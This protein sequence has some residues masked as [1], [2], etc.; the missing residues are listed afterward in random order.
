MRSTH[1]N[2]IRTIPRSSRYFAATVGVAILLG[3]PSALWAQVAPDLGA[4][5]PFVVLGANSIPVIG[6]VTCTDTGPGVGIGAGSVGTT[7][8]GGITNTGCTIAGPIVSPVPGGVVTAFNSALS[9]IDTQNAVCTGV[10]PIVSTVLPPGVYCSPAGT[11]IGAGVTL[12]LS[13]TAT[14]VWIFRV[15]TGGPGALT[16][17]GATIAMAGAAQPCNVF[18]K[19]SAA[20]T[21]TDSTFRGTVLSGAA[22]TM[23]RTTWTGRAMAATNVTLT[24]PDMTFAGC[25]AS[26]PPGTITV[27]KDFSPNNPQTVPVALT[28]TSGTVTATPLTFSE[29]APAVFTVTGAS[30]GVTCTATETVPAN[31]T[32]NQAGCV[33]V[34]LNGSCTIIN[35]LAAASCPTTFAPAVIPNGTVGNAYSVTFTGSAGVAPYTF[36]VA[37]GTLPAGLT[38]TSAGVLSGTPTTAGSQTFIITVTDAIGCPESRQYTVFISSGLTTPLPGCPV[39]TLAPETLPSGVV[40]VAYSQTITGSGGTAPYIFTQVAG[41]IPVG[42]TLTTAGVLAGT[43]TRSLLPDSLTI[44]GTDSSGLGCF[45]EI[46][47]TM[48]V[49]EG[50]PTLPQAFA[51]M[52]T[53]SLMWLGYRQLR[54]RQRLNTD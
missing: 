23:T 42:L 44:R 41:S 35:T 1:D 10:I 11:T 26:L 31:Y 6:T 2:T 53:L 24:D 18:W 5:A 54:K 8:A 3:C 20:T 29:A 48:G 27:N 47:Y 33:A 21:L 13:G 14:D 12:T 28:C 22:V 17:T 16:L 25:A 50:V 30:A 49:V 46:V 32:A 43:P 38:L 51:V 45:A 19:T 52:L 36:T 34:A 7:F 39:I 15:G 40:G 9:A 37:P 4:A